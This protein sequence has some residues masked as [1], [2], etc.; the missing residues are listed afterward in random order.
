M[1]GNTKRED[2]DEILYARFM[3]HDVNSLNMNHES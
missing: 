1:A 2:S 3:L